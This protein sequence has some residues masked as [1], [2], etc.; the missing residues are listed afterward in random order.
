MTSTTRITLTQKLAALILFVSTL[1]ISVSARDILAE[2]ESCDISSEPCSF[3]RIPDD[4]DWFIPEQDG[5]LCDY[6]YVK[7]SDGKYAI[8]LSEKGTASGK[9]MVATRDIFEYR[10]YS[11]F[12]NDRF[13]NHR[14]GKQLCDLHKI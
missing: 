1:F 7:K 9:I 8:I 13:L 5:Y 10:Y 12:P 11:S 6:K 4:V 2:A 3:V 14:I